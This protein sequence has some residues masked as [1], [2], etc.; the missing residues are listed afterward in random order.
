MVARG[1]LLTIGFTCLALSTQAYLLKSEAAPY[2]CVP[3]A[4]INAIV[5]LTIEERLRCKEFCI[6]YTYTY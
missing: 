3:D 5:G 2:E 6:R 1:L 4:E